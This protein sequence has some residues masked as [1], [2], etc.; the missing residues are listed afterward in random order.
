MMLYPVANVDL[1]FLKRNGMVGASGDGSRVYRIGGACL[2]SRGHY[3]PFYPTILD[4]FRPPLTQGFD[5]SLE[6]T[7]ALVDALA[8]GGGGGSRLFDRQAD[9]VEMGEVLGRLSVVRFLEDKLFRISMNL[10]DL[11]EVYRAEVRPAA[12]K[13]DCLLEIKAALLAGMNTEIEDRGRTQARLT[14][15]IHAF[16][17]QGGEIKS[18]IGPEAPHLNDV[19]EVVCP[20]CS[21]E[22]KTRKTFPLLFCRAC[23]QEYYSTASR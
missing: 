5:G 22:G 16:F 3:R 19:G 12:P 20:D 4:N 8:G 17:N 11:V 2:V 14:P 6:K 18:C 9:R 15:K 7:R 10:D 23:G 13:E 21:K 1:L